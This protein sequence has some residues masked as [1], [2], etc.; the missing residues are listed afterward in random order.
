VRFVSCITLSCL[1]DI[2]IVQFISYQI[3][4]FVNVFV[5][6]ERNAQ[7]LTFLI[8]KGFGNKKLVNILFYN[9]H[10]KPYSNEFLRSGIYNN[11]RIV[12]IRIA[13]L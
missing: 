1:I 8:I 10:I 13:G 4:N 3:I 6:L 5:T 7:S 2:H 11:L 12:T 9:S